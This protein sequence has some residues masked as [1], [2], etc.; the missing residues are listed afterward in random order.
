MLV[1]HKPY[2][3][4]AAVEALIELQHGR[5]TNARIHTAQVHVATQVQAYRAIW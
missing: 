3:F 1:A 4:D 2:L 5:D